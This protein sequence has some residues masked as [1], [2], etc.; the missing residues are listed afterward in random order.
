MERRD[1]RLAASLAYVTMCLMDVIHQVHFP[2]PMQE[3]ESNVLDV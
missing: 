2:Q 3:M 1:A